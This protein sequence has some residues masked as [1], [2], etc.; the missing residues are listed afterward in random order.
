MLTLQHFNDTGPLSL[1]KVYDKI[2]RCKTY[3]HCVA[4]RQCFF[5]QARS[6]RR[7]FA[8]R[9]STVCLPANVSVHNKTVSRQNVAGFKAFSLSTRHGICN[10]MKQKLLSS[11]DC[12]ALLSSFMCCV[13]KRKERETCGKSQP[14]VATIINIY[15]L[16]LMSSPII[17]FLKYILKG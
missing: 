17:S 7:T 12:S 3:K 11:L 8:V 10:A 16:L 5:T 13:S 1:L 15:V 4:C 2:K 6:V 9:N 14:S